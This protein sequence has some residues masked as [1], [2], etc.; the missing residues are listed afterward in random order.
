MNIRVANIHDIAQ[1]QVIRNSVRE[2]TLSDPSLIRD[3]YYMEFLSEKGNGWICEVKNQV[4]GFAIVD[5]KGNK[6][7]ALFIHP[8][9]E[10]KGIGKALHTTMLDWYFAQ[11]K[12]TIW[13]G[14]A[15]N[16][17]A[18]SFYR[19]AGW[20]HIGTHGNKEIKFEMTYENWIHNR[21]K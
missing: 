21:L 17:R 14:T 19:K 6:I 1:M 4:V 20:K 13:L 11:T 8:D 16:T 15:N 12:S 3:E 9:F 2:N 7:W 10:K 18:E 5:V